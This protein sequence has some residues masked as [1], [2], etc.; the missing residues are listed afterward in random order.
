MR[1]TFTAPPRALAAGLAV[2]AATAALS[3]AVA[4]RAFSAG[5]VT[6]T[7]LKPPATAALEECVTAQQQSERSATFSGEMS[8][9]PGTARMEMR[10]DVQERDPGA[11]TFHVVTAPGLGVWRDAAPGVKTFRYLKQVTN[12]AAPAFYRAD[13]RFRWLNAKGHAIRWDEL[14]TQRCLQT[15]AVQEEPPADGSGLPTA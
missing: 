8:T 3:L 4:P 11:T 5:R 10:I 2:A 6:R 14:L 13:V 9:L 1:D 7:D 15:V 12:L